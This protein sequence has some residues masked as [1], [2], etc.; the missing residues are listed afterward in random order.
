MGFFDKLLGKS[1]SSS[2]SNKSSSSSIG[3]SSQPGYTGISINSYGLRLKL[4]LAYFCTTDPKYGGVD[5]SGS[6]KILQGWVVIGFLGPA[7][8]TYILPETFNGLPIIGID[9]LAYETLNEYQQTQYEGCYNS[10]HLRMAVCFSTNRV[11]FVF[12][13]RRYSDRKRVD[14]DYYTLYT[15]GVPSVVNNKVNRAFFFNGCMFS[16]STKSD[17]LLSAL[18]RNT[19]CPRDHGYTFVR[20]IRDHYYVMRKGVREKVTVDVGLDQSTKAT[21]QTCHPEGWNL[22][23]KIWPDPMFTFGYSWDMLRVGKYFRVPEGIPLNV[24]QVFDQKESVLCFMQDFNGNNY[25]FAFNTIKG[26]DVIINCASD[27]PQVLPRAH[28]G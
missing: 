2:G 27:F 9:Y 18:I 6:M 11:K 15:A 21:Y 7:D 19:G 26:T 13:P 3:S 28:S 10:S 5:S 23:D 16:Y 25:P 17:T 24:S 22:L 8:R 1:S 14:V 4:R 20:Q 12:P